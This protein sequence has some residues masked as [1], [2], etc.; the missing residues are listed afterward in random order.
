[1]AG[2]ARAALAGDLAAAFGVHRGEAPAGAR[3]VRIQV[4]HELLLLWRRVGEGA[5]APMT[6]LSAAAPDRQRASG[7]RG[8]GDGRGNMGGAEEGHG[9]SRMVA[10]KQTNESAMRLR[11]KNRDRGRGYSRRSASMGSSRAA[12]H[13]G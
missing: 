9:V 1:F 12:R 11:E 10:L 13:E 4:G 8:R 6:R 3:L 7:G 2:H 5:R